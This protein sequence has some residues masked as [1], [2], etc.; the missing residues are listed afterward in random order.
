MRAQGTEGAVRARV[1][2][3]D[4]C[5]AQDKEGAKAEVGDIKGA[6]ILLRTTHGTVLGTHGTR[7]GVFFKVRVVLNCVLG[8]LFKWPGI[9]ILVGNSFRDNGKR[10]GADS[11]TRAVLSRASCSLTVTKG[12][13]C[14]LT[15]TKGRM[16]SLTVTGGGTR[17]G[18]RARDTTK[19]RK[20]PVKGEVE[21]WMPVK[22]TLTHS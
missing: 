2:T 19:G 8:T 1:S 15:V 21:A 10:L 13:M 20:V 4:V 18:R 17:Q 12:R 7:S 5:L 3:G 6:T 22:D 9:G 16:C 11:G 14:S